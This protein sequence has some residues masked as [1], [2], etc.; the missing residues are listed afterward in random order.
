MYR[1]RTLGCFL[2]FGLI[3]GLS[4]QTA[5]ADQITTVFVTG[6]F[7]NG[8]ALSGNYV[9]D[10][11]TGSAVSADL[12]VGSVQFNVAPRIYIGAEF[13]GIIVSTNPSSFVP[14][15]LLGLPTATACSTL[16]ACAAGITI[17]GPLCSVSAPCGG[18]HS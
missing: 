4:A 17:P 2:V 3:F 6:T 1:H 14:D 12:F 18:A 7:Q 5:Q 11:T 8:A 10:V 9:V 16:L 15:L 13:G